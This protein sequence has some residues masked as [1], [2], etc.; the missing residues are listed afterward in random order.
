MKEN[1]V[2]L[3]LDRVFQEFIGIDLGEKFT[4]PCSARVEMNT[5]SLEKTYRSTTGGG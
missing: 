3:G 4:G 2:G 1:W 5:I